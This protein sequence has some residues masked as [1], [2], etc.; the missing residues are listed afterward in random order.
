LAWSPNKELLAVGSEHGG[1][2]LW[3]LPKI[4]AQL[5][6]IGLGW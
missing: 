5:A 1:I 3:N 6:E 2:A 4:K